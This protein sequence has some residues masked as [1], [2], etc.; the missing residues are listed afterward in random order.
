MSRTDYQETRGRRKVR[1]GFRFPTNNVSNVALA[2]IVQDA[3]LPIATAIV[4]AATGQ[5][6][7]TF[8]EDF[9][10]L[11]CCIPKLQ[12][13]TPDGSECVMISYTRATRVL[14]LQTEDETGSGAAIAAA[15][16]NEVHVAIEFDGAVTA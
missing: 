13:A 9:G 2:S 5:L 4:Y 14:L 11:L 12:M 10:A 16:N 3:S 15:T 7:I 8:A 6:S 1:L